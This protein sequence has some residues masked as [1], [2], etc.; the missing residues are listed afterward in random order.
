MDSCELRRRLW[1]ALAETKHSVEGA[2]ILVQHASDSVAHLQ[3]LCEDVLC[4]DVFERPKAADQSPR[5]DLHKFTASQQFSMNVPTIKVNGVDG[6]ARERDQTCP[7]A[8]RHTE[9]QTATAII[10]NE[11]KPPQ[12]QE[13]MAAPQ[14]VHTADTRSSG[15][16]KNTVNLPGDHVEQDLPMPKNSVQCQT[17]GIAAIKSQI[18]AK[19][20]DIPA[21]EQEVMFLQPQSI[22]GVEPSMPVGAGK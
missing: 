3:V 10:R 22:T 16:M 14:S 13:S 6:V 12:I 7:S 11:A 18:D 4:E 5:A 21:E 19:E 8:D 20:E 17:A 1:N 15:M 9:L 2:L